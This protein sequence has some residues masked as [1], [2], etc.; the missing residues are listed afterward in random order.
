MPNHKGIITA[1]HRLTAE[2]AEHMLRDGGNAFDAALAGLTAAC[3][4]EPLLASLG[5]GGFM[6]AQP[7]GEPVRAYDFFTHTPRQ[8]CPENETDFYSVLVDFGSATQEFHIGRGSIAVPGVVRGLFDIHRDLATI[9]MRVL[10]EPALDYATDGF[11]VSSFH[12]Y[13]MKLLTEIFTATAP[14][15]RLFA[16]ASREGELVAEGDQLCLPEL[17][18]VLDALSLEGADLFYR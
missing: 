1:G 14:A 5:G 10:M 3:V 6:L 7:A 15:E 2:A 13:V 18:N 16:S 4:A 17:G 9:P 12:A 8:R 11:E